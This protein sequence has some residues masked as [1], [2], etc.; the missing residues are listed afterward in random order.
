MTEWFKQYGTAIIALAGV[1]LGA[2]V[3]GGL[4]FLNGWVMRNRDLKLKLWERFLDHRIAAHE[5]VVAIA[6][7]MRRMVPLGRF[8]KGEVVRSPQVM[9]SR[10]AF[11]QWLD[12]FA[13]IAGP[14]ST[15]L[16]TPVKR[17][18][19]F[20]QDYFVTV[21]QNL[22]PFPS[23][24]L[25]EVGSFIRQDFIDLSSKLEK[26]AF[27]YF[28]EEALDLRLNDL[29]EWHK[30]PLPETEARLKDTAILQRWAEIKAMIQS[31]ASPT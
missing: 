26:L 12:E 23:E 20:A 1:C 16:S 10:E 2:V 24:C 7:K 11:D 31:G 6:L 15:W 19:N 28:K 13:E 22:L 27:E 9:M 30:Y 25:P 3:T 14:A 18:L 29:T 21:H 8:E 17:E 4:T 5:A